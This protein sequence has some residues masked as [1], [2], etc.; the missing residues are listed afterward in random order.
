[1]DNLQ[2]GAGTGRLRQQTMVVRLNAWM[3]PDSNPGGYDAAGQQFHSEKAGKAL[4]TFPAAQTRRWAFGECFRR[5]A[6][7]F[8]FTRCHHFNSASYFSFLRKN[9]TFIVASQNKSGIQARRDICWPARQQAGGVVLTGNQVFCLRRQYGHPDAKTA[10]AKGY[11][12]SGQ[13]HLQA[14]YADMLRDPDRPN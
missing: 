13:L 5:S 1:M 14:G 6:V 11:G 3:V 9:T 10:T 4:I 2:V 12:Q 8:I 7:G